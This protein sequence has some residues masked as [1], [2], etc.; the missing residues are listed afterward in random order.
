MA[1]ETE[2][3]ASLLSRDDIGRGFLPLIGNMLLLLIKVLTR[4]RFL[5][6]TTRDIYMYCMRLKIIRLT[7]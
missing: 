7:Q 6:I 5:Q 4:K 2:C 3:V 1:F